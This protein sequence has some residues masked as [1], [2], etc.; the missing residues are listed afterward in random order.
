MENSDNSKYIQDLITKYPK[1]GAEY[2][3][4]NNQQS[5]NNSPTNIPVKK[6]LVLAKPNPKS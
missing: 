5:S 3:K 1:W 4:R 2:L 6:P